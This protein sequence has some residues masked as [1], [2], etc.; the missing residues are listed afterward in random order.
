MRSFVQIH[1]ALRTHACVCI[2]GCVGEWN[3]DSEKEERDVLY[4]SE[5]VCTLTCM[6]KSGRL[7]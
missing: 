2:C 4:A 7:I 5:C 6:K 1:G 3:H